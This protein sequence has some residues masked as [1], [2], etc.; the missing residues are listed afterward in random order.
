[1]KSSVAPYQT[2][3]LCLR[4]VCGNGTAIRVTRYPK[5]LT[6]SNG[7]V[8]ITGS[9]FDF[10]GYE[11]TASLSPSAIDLEG[12]LGFAGVT[13]EAVASGVFDGAR[14]YLFACDYL[15]P[16]EDHEPIVAS[17]LGK[18][19]LTDSGYTFEE[20]A[21]IDALNQ[22]V[23]R[24]YMAQCPKTFGGQE[25]AGC[26]IALGPLTVS[27]TLTAVTSGTQFAD[28]TRPEAADYFS[29]GTVQFTSG[30]NAGLKPLEIKSFSAG[31]G[32]VTFEPFYYPP[33]IGDAYVMTPG[34]RKRLE[35]CR[36]KWNNVVNFGGFPSM[37]TSSI[38]T[39]RGSK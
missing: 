27:G 21:L 22:S 13:R 1:M 4:I 37:P 32:I 24:T 9:G 17:F 35:D 16:V 23:G 34:C 31:G 18:A 20:M 5:D 25:Y 26:K 10:T 29:L 39:Q 14:A 28:N 36:D 30:A 12:I 19:T 3:A 11:S 7:Q 6:M 15:N 8:Y 2:S 33:A 38:Y